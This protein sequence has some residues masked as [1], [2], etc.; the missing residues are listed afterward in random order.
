MS[1][2]AA[3]VWRH[4]SD[5]RTKPRVHVHFVHSA[6]NCQLENELVSVDYSSKVGEKQCSDVRKRR[7]SRESKI[8]VC[9]SWLRDLLPSLHLQSASSLASQ[10]YFS[11]FPVGGARREKYVWTLCQLACALVSFPDQRQSHLTWERDYMCACVQN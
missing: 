1:T 4:Q 8:K 9:C 2:S 7:K 5:Y 6:K 11:L 10:P 3:L